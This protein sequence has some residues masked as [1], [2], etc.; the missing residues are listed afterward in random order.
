MF[1]MQREEKWGKKVQMKGLFPNAGRY[2]NSW[3]AAWET[4]KNTFSNTKSL[5]GYS[6]YYDQG[7]SGYYQ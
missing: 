3:L 6:L 4:G 2:K 5:I 7:M 1:L